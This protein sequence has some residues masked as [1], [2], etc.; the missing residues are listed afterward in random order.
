MQLR[1]MTLLPPPIFASEA[2]TFPPSGSTSMN[3]S[4]SLAEVEAWLAM[5][6]KRR[7]GELDEYVS[8]IFVFI[9]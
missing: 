6:C 4:P 2:V 1:I 8:W 5:A 9:S 7:V 3:V